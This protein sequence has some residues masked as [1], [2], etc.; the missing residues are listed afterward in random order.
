MTTDTKLLEQQAYDFLS[1]DNFA[2]AFKLFSRAA[3]AYRRAGSHQKAAICFASAASCWGKKCGERTFCNSAASYE[4]AAREAYKVGDYEYAALLYKYAAIN[5]E[6]DREFL[7][8]SECFYSSR[9]TYREFLTY[10]F[11]KPNKIK[12]IVPIPEEKGIVGF[13]KRLIAWLF[14]TISFVVWGHGERPMRTFFSGIFI[15]AGSAFLYTFGNL[16]Q[17]GVIFK[18]NF[19]QA[20]YFSIVTFTTVGYGDISPVGWG[21]LIVMAEAFSG[22]FVMPL[23]L[24]G[25]SRK[26]LRI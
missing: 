2:E 16:M 7:N 4:S 13:F 5:F 23:F 22:I 12:S 14:L 6:R 9:E 3:E 19:F 24:I 8:F 11:F 15:I 25:L 20:L 21:K 1:K 26:Y 10:R 17:D 18:P